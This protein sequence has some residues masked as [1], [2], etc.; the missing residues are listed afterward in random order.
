MVANSSPLP[1]DGST[2]ENGVAV[3]TKRIQVEQ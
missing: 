3:A 2:I 1:S